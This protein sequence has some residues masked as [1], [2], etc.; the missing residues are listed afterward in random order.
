M[1]NL[2]EYL[3]GLN[4]QEVINV[5]SQIVSQLLQTIQ[6]PPHPIAS[7]GNVHEYMNGALN[8]AVSL[9]MVIYSQTVTNIRFDMADESQIDE[10]KKWF[11]DVMI[12]PSLELSHRQG[13]ERGRDVR[14]HYARNTMRVAE[15]EKQLS[16]L[17]KQLRKLQGDK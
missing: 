4:K 13:I 14:V 7:G 10:F 15:L 2:E 1:T 3:K 9:C 12:M 6:Y 11:L 8:A 5:Y 17:K 16:S